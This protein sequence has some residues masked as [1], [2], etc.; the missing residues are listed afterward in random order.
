ME[1]PPLEFRIVFLNRAEGGGHRNLKFIHYRDIQR[2]EHTFAEGRVGVLVANPY[3]LALQLEHGEAVGF[4]GDRIDGASNVILAEI[5]SLVVYL[6]PHLE[7]AT[8]IQREGVRLAFSPAAILR[9]G[10][11]AD[12]DGRGEAE[13]HL[14]AIQSIHGLDGLHREG[15]PADRAGKDVTIAGVAGEVVLRRGL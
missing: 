7:A 15:E 12:L 9:P 10:L 14:G 11:E 5:P 4:D 6:T 1:H 2:A 13:F 3:Q 8:G